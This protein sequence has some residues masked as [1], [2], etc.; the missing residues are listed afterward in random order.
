MERKMASRCL[1]LL[2]RIELEINTHCNKED[3]Y[4]V[5]CE[6]CPNSVKE[7][8]IDPPK[9]MEDEVYE[10]IIDELQDL[11]FNGR[12]SY[13]FYGE[14]LLHK[15][16][17]AIIRYSA[18]KLP[19]AEKVLYTNGDRLT[20]LKYDGLIKSGIDI[21][22][23]SKH[24]HMK[25]HIPSRAKQ[26]VLN[27]YNITNR[28]GVFGNS[29]SLTTPCYAF[30]HRLVVAY[31]GDVLLCYEDAKRETVLGN[32]KDKSISE[33]WSS[34]K[35]RRIRKNLALGRRDLYVPCKRCNNTAHSRL[36]QVHVYDF[37]KI[38]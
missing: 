19:K 11:A 33:I 4:G 22:A 9:C 21:I 25:E 28:G 13:H 20:D 10:K 5:Y 36:N 35:S 37:K 18:D 26:V 17:E 30:N 23:V 31:N 3:D 16:I 1:H 2:K 14:P 6:Y 29:E 32:I 27:K 8:I 15:K 7:T 24:K 34:E 38:F 12:I